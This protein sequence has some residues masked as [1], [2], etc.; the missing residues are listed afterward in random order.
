ML[1]T[2]TV[3]LLTK[4]GRKI[5][6]NPTLGSCIRQQV[7]TLVTVTTAVTEW[8]RDR[9]RRGGIKGRRVTNEAGR[10]FASKGSMSA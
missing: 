7:V 1:H 4:K 5:Y 9:D 2:Y 8:E 6:K 10:F 3:S